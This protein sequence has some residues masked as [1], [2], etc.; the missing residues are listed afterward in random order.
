MAFDWFMIANGA[1]VP[2]I[3]LQTFYHPLIWV[4]SLWGVMLP[5]ST[6]ALAVLFRRKL[7]AL[8]EA[9]EVGTEAAV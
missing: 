7:R 3:A 5:G 9:S 4:A 1:I 2:F 6:I 8:D